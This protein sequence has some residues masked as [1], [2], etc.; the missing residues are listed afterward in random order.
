MLPLPLRPV[1]V[2]VTLPPTL[3]AALMVTVP[4]A[5]KT[6]LRLLPRMPPG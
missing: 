1:V 6:R 2:M 4:A 5:C 3:I